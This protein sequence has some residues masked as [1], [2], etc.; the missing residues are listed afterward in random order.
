MT[1]NSDSWDKF[2]Y[3]E[4]H[5]E[6][7]TERMAKYILPNQS[8]VDVGC[9]EMKLLKYLPD[10]CSYLGIDLQKRNEET[11]VCNFNKEALPKIV[12]DVY[13][14]A[15]VL[16]YAIDPE[17]LIK[18]ISSNTSDTIICSYCILEDFPQNVRDDLKWANSLTQKDIN[19][20][21]NKNGFQVHNTFKVIRN[22]IFI[23]KRQTYI[24]KFLHFFG[25]RAYTKF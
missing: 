5:W 11:V 6:E 24:R 23:A 20:L 21:F 14:I 12:S 15:G 1:N 7:R 13:F 17:S 9:G 25:V 16:E 2:E 18:Q 3:F 10:N 22:T 19:I 8:V 4:P